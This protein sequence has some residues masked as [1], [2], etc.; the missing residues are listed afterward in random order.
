MLAIKKMLQSSF[1]RTPI[2]SFGLALLFPYLRETFYIC[3]PD[4]ITFNT[5][6]DLLGVPTAG[7]DD[8]CTIRKAIK[9]GLSN[10]YPA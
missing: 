8:Y 5:S 2:I 3:L 9:N 1:R 4:K 10:Q 6:P 7:H